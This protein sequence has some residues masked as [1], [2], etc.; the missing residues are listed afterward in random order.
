MY[1][2]RFDMN[3]ESLVPIIEFQVHSPTAITSPSVLMMPTRA[4]KI[5][6]LPTQR[7]DE[8]VIRDAGE[9]H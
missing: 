3:N 9:T 8:N 7:S 5:R 2:T 4:A 6:R 1:E